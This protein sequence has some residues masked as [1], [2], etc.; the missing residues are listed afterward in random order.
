MNHD[1]TFATTLASS[2]DMEFRS[3]SINTML[4]N[5]NDIGTCL[6]F[7]AWYIGS[8]V[9]F[10]ITCVGVVL[11]TILFEF[12]TR[13]FAE[14]EHHKQARDAGNPQESFVPLAGIELALLQPAAAQPDP[15]QPDPAQPV[16][17]EPGP[18]EPG[19]AQSADGQSVGAQSAHAQSVGA[20]SVGAQSA[21]AQPMASRPASAS[22]PSNVQDAGAGI[23]AGNND[24]VNNGGV[25][26]G[27]VNN[28]INAA[29]RV[30]PLFPRRVEHALI[31]TLLRTL[32]LAI[33]YLIILMAVSFNGYI[34]ICIFIGHYLGFFLFGRNP[35]TRSDKP[36]AYQRAF[37]R[38]IAC[39]NV[40]ETYDKVNIWATR[41][42]RRLTNCLASSW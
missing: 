32:M 15:A 25:N 28:G 42:W 38:R 33:N 9:K 27:S 24:G 2:S 7:E 8:T 6:I 34:I 41:W 22:G 19:P 26:N 3:C 23:N 11:V 39:C 1:P 31:T 17:A 40:W 4:W 14:W 10:I 29:N 16:A 30:L 36:N 20:Q 37:Q 35:D 18:A 12:L 21:H 13:V 5:W